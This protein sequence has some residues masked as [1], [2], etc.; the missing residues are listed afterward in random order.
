VSKLLDVPIGFR[1]LTSFGV[2]LVLL[3]S[4]ALLSYSSVESIYSALTSFASN[5]TPA[6]SYLL[7]ADRDLHQLLVA[8]RSMIFVNTK[9]AE[10]KDLVKDYETNLEQARKRI[11]KFRAL[12]DLR[13]ADELFAGFETAFE[14]WAKL[15]RQIVDGRIADTR[16]GRRLALDLSMKEAS[17]AFEEMR[18][19]IDKFTELTSLQIENDVKGAEEKH[20]VALT[21]LVAFSCG[22]ILIG[23]LLSWLIS[24]SVTKPLASGVVFA[25]AVAEGNLRSELSVYQKDEVGQLA[26]AMRHML[27]KLKTT[28]EH[29]EQ[30]SR[31]AE[32]AAEN[33][34]KSSEEAEEARRRGEAARRE[35]ILEAVSKLQGIVQSLFE[36][37]EQM[38][39]HVNESQAGATLQMERANESTS[40]ME[41]MNLTVVDVAKNASE[42]A[43]N[44][45]ETQQQALD[46]EAIVRSVVAT[47]DEV[48]RISIEMKQNLDML[49][50]SAASI[51]QIM[52][53]INDI[54][55]QTNLLALNAA[56]EAARA[57]EAGRG[58][59]VVADEVRKLAEKTMQATKQV[60][61]AIASIQSSSKVSME[62]MESVAGAIG[63][64][65]DFADKAGE[66]LAGIVNLAQATSA[67]IQA[68][69]AASEEQS[70]SVEMITQ[71]SEEISRISSETSRTM[72]EAAEAIMVLSERSGDLQKLIDEL[73]RS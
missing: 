32:L 7:E 35:G 9:Q 37:S 55:D 70:T 50:E 58:F 66:S 10:F 59:A 53:V 13:D 22:G 64:A 17:Q 60:G 8:E 68:I 19:Y 15:S 29:A 63:K 41:E 28:L 11:D 73:A 69:A 4:S 25:Q 33:A 23:L 21:T 67:Q 44:A 16:E 48:N 31:E 30:K 34:R 20:Q 49:G 47:I 71:S 18:G 6:L 45:Q 1:L 38:G 43:T 2:M 12:S 57:G 72:D 26:D 65:T 3:V 14:A 56:I 39:R 24:R 61:D 40:A 51:G 54:A 42:A 5:R 62:S 36:A 52:V 27:S 46:G